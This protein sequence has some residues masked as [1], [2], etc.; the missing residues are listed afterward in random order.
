QLDGATRVRVPDDEVVDDRPPERS[1]G[2]AAGAGRAP[3][4]AAAGV[5]VGVV[6][7]TEVRGTPSARA[8]LECPRADL[9]D[10]A[11]GS[12][13]RVQLLD[14]ALGSAH[15]LGLEERLRALG[16]AQVLERL[17]VPGLHAALPL[18]GALGAV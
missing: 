7:V 8:K 3:A 12:A 16:L 10:L 15:R 17:Q 11:L 1:H 2:L 6:E 4:L 5:A 18:R 13:H 9:L 14:L